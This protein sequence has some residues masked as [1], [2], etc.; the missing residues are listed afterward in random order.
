M[1]VTRSTERNT[2][3]GIH[4]STI[5][6]IETQTSRKLTIE[7]HPT[8][9]NLALCNPQSQ[10]PLFSIL[11]PEIRNYIF[12]LALLQYED[13]AN[14]YKE[15]ALWYR[16]GHRARR[17]VSTS[18]LL[19][20]RLIWLEANHWPM[21]Q[22]VHDFWY[23][24]GNRPDW[25]EQRFADDELRFD[26]FL[27][28][29]TDLQFSR[30]KRVRIFAD[31]GWLEWTGR[32]NFRERLGLQ[33]HPLRLDNFTVTVRHVDW[34]NWEFDG[35]L[36]LGGSWLRGLL[37]S[38][39]ATRF[40]EVCLELETL[41]WKVGRLRRIVEKLRSAGEAK[42]GENV[43][44]ELVEPFE[45]RTWSG[46]TNLND[47][48]LHAQTIYEGRN[49]LEYRVI[50]MKWKRLIPTQLERR[51]RKERSLLKLS[52]HSRPVA[53]A[54]CEGDS[55]GDDIGAESEGSAYTESDWLE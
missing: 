11:P 38:P 36:R 30:V 37:R 23:H 21:T 46:P 22:A 7:T 24:E 47:D 13:L 48:V 34:M 55:G 4:N 26:D 15:C 32:T 43:R 9:E 16:P 42:K 17:I 50:T 2:C 35:M 31:V 41:E 33:R 20:C 8:P 5:H 12:S 27:R 3:S 44:W 51:W 6:Q 18:L 45:E 49:K 29:L 19:T 40:A 39:E 1:R 52:E 14:P 10:S 53:R 28:R 54:E 25:T